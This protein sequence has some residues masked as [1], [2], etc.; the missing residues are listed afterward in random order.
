[1]ATSRDLLLS[2]LAL[3]SYNRGYAVGINVTGNQ[4]GTA[5]IT[6]DSEPIAGSQAVSFYAT[7]YNLGGE[8]I[9]S[10]RGTTFEAS[11]TFSVG[12]SGYLNGRSVA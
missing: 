12:C 6:R 9:I 1:M 5:L 8:T 2:I 11:S 3:D 10:Y 7:A 4:I